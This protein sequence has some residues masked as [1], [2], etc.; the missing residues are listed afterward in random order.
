MENLFANMM[1]FQLQMFSELKTV[2]LKKDGDGSEAAAVG[3]SRTTS[4]TRIEP[5]QS[6][7]ALNLKV[8]PTPKSIQSRPDTASEKTSRG[9]HRR[10]ASTPATPTGGDDTDADPEPDPH[11]AAAENKPKPDQD[12]TGICADSL[13][14]RNIRFSGPRTVLNIPKLRRCEVLIIEPW[15]NR[16]E[17][18]FLREG[19]TEDREKG[20]YLLE[21]IDFSLLEELSDMEGK[22]FQELK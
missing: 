13:P 9:I 11:T 22:G 6:H 20:L 8:P 16:L 14:G 2:L 10:S 19:I 1:N 3:S 15:L 7:R 5:S 12:S 21:N 18:W 17:T 4:D